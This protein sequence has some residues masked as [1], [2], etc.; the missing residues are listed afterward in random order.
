M[1]REDLH[2][3]RIDARTPYGQR[4]ADDPEHHAGNPQLQAQ[5]DGGG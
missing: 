5:P 4:V 3:L 2:E 1:P